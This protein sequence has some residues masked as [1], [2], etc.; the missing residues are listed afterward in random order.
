MALKGKYLFFGKVSADA[1]YAIV[2]GIQIAKGGDAS[3]HVSVYAD[4]PVSK[5][6]QQDTLVN[7]IVEKVDVVQ[8]DRGPVIEHMTLGGIKVTSSPFGDCYAGVKQD[9]RFKLM[10]DA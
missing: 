5:T 4:S 3:V 7:G 8:M 2:D 1:A 10:S 6:V 9:E